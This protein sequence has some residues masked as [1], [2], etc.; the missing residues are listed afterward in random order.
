MVFYWAAHRQNWSLESVEKKRQRDTI[1]PPPVLSPRN[2]HTHPG[3]SVVFP[4][5]WFITNVDLN[6]KKNIAVSRLFSNKWAMFLFNWKIAVVLKWGFFPSEEGGVSQSGK[7]S[8][9]YSTLF[10]RK[11]GQA[12]SKFETKLICLVIVEELC[13]SPTLREKHF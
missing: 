5:D 6:Y 2:C 11:I 3:L 12:L 8:A 13:G 7:L 4:F 10:W 1:T 9:L